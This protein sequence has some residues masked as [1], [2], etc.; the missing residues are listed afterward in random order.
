MPAHKRMRL[1]VLAHLAA[2]VGIANFGNA[3]WASADAWGHG[4][5]GFLTGAIY[6]QVGLLAIWVGFARPTVGSWLARLAVASSLCWAILFWQQ[7]LPNWRMEI[8]RLPFFQVTANYSVFTISWIFRRTL[9]FRL[10]GHAA[11]V[12]VGLSAVLLVYRAKVARI[13]IANSTPASAPGARLQFSI[14]SMLVGVLVTAVLLGLARLTVVMGPSASFDPLPTL[15][16]R[17]V[18]GESLPYVLL[19]ACHA[20]TGFIM[21]RTALGGMRV[22][23]LLAL[24]VGMTLMIA[25]IRFVTETNAGREF[26]LVGT[27]VAKNE[28]IAAPY[29]GGEA[30]GFVATLL[31]S[32]LVVR[33]CGYRFLPQATSSTE[34]S[35]GR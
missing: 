31:A 14:R 1:L 22:T 7:R 33:S 9:Y 25:A 35:E 10:L 6:G 11:V 8:F 2:A 15:A 29:L 5:L 19:A 34:A 32:L 27:Y 17:T 30:T 23:G 16:L 3:M 13:E 12:L 28:F 20:L 18:F 4:F 26:L 21:L 24:S